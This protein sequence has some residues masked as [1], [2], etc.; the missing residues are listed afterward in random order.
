MRRLAKSARP[1]NHRKSVT[2]LTLIIF[3][4]IFYVDELKIT[5]HQQRV[6]CSR[7]RVIERALG[8][9]HQS[10][11]FAFVLEKDILSTCCNK[12]NVIHKH[13]R[14]LR[15]TAGSLLL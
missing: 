4:F 2:Y 3:V 14:L 1:Q 12:S 11:P 15:A 13:T 5:T 6:S 10:P 9:W 8:E 7:S